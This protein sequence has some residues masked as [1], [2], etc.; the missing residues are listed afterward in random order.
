MQRK[1]YAWIDLKDWGIVLRLHLD[2]KLFSAMLGPI[3]IEVKG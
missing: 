2:F 1:W 3:G